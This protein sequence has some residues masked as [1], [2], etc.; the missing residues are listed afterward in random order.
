M[1]YKALVIA[2][3]VFILGNLAVLREDAQRKCDIMS[4]APCPLSA[5]RVR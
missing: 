2:L 4:V 1:I 5:A 3:L